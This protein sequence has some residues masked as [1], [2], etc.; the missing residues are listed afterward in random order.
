MP[1][2]TAES[3]LQALKRQVAFLT[4]RIFRLEQRLGAAAET[5]PAPLPAPPAP[6]MVP[7]A[8][9]PPPRTD[10]PPAAVILSGRPLP[11]M[12]EPEKHD[13]EKKIGQYWL[14][15]IGIVAVLFGVAYFLKYAFDNHWIGPSGRV[16][17]GLLVGIALMVW[18]ER[19]R[20][21]GYGAFSLSLKA[22][23]IGVLYL[24][25]WAAFS[26][27]QLVSS[28]TAFV[29]MVVVTAATIV[30]SLTQ[31]SQLLSLF[32]I[33]GGYATPVLVSTG[34]NHEI[35]L[36]TYVGMLSLAVLA[37]AVQKP[38]RRL[39]W[40][41][42]V[43][44]HLLFWGWFV[45]Y[46]TKS[47][48]LPTL[49]FAI[50]FAVIF[51]LVPVLAKDRRPLF[52]IKTSLTLLLLPIFNA[53]LVFLQFWAMYSDSDEVT[54]LAWFSLGLA[55]AYLAL[56]SLIRR[57]VAK[58]V[59][60]ESLLISLMHVSVAIVFINIAIP[61]KVHDQRNCWIT[62]GWLVEAAALFWISTRVNNADF[63]RVLGGCALALGLFR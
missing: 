30:L 3:E 11:P 8:A 49:L 24:S 4:T 60:P 34:Q 25:L 39:V 31:D 48:R 32:G 61:L 13:L 18:S 17:I 41:G 50:A 46:Y 45:T 16:T 23:G 27:Y 1:D 12:A 52:K 42:L 57:R 10:T 59:A 44:T 47:Q 37:M 62:V 9:A 29:A 14:N 51:A 36:F 58:E 22:V 21:R 43:G 40:G 56:A 63:V 26:L 5:Q 19:F 2:V 55:A 35:V 38:W 6:A 54:T 53:S 33:I 15:R 28:G 20:R 7:R